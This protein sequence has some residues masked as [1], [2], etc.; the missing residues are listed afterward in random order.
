MELGYRERPHQH[1]C[2]QAY[3]LLRSQYIFWL[4]FLL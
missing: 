1:L 4:R 2:F 3:P